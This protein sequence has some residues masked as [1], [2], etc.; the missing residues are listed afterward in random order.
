MSTSG[1]RVRNLLNIGVW[2]ERNFED[3]GIAARPV[4][5]QVREASLHISINRLSIELRPWRLPG[6]APN[7]WSW[8]RLSSNLHMI[9]T[10]FLFAEIYVE[11]KYDDDDIYYRQGDWGPYHDELVVRRGNART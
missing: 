4:E 9:R 11:D 2:A 3:Y 1:K 6:A 8:A 7:R 5:D 10:P